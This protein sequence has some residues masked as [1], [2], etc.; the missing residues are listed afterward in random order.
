M[1]YDYSFVTPDFNKNSLIKDPRKTEK[2]DKR[3]LEMADVYAGWSKDPSSKIGVVI[4][5]PESHRVLSGGY[6][7]FPRGV[8]DTPDRLNDRETKYRFTVHAEQ[9][10]IYNATLNGVPLKGSTLYCS[11]LPTC[12]ECAK[13][14]IQVGITRVVCH[15]P[16]SSDK[17]TMDKWN[18]SWEFTRTMFDEV[19]IEYKAYT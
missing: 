9:N 12:S 19:R 16:Q 14:I 5:D 10:A 1:D 7:G 2:W 13:A 17:D 8:L 18:K 6:N 4:V 15:W 3:F 11:G